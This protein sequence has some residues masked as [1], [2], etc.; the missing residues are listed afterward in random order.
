MADKQ[1]SDRFAAE[2]AA[3]FDDFTKW[4]IENWPNKD[5]PLLQSDFS[6]S[7]KE[8]ALMLGGRLS[9]GQTAGPGAPPAEDSGQYVNMNPAPWP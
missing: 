7:R 1:A 5:L 8:I 2:M 4:A 9:E 3:R 6:E